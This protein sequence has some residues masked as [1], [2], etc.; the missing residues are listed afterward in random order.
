MKR[1]FAIAGLMT[2]AAISLTNCQPKEIGADLIPAGKTVYISAS[3]DAGVKTTNDGVKTLWAENDAIN[4]FCTSGSGYTDLGE[5]TIADGVGTTQAT[6]AVT[7]TALPAEDQEVTWYAMYPYNSYLTTPGT[8]TDARTYIGHSVSIEQEG[9]DNMDKL[10]D[11]RCPMYGVA[12]GKI[13][14]VNIPMKHLT[15]VVEFNITNNSGSGLTVK[16]V[17]MTASEDIVGQ[18]YIA[19]DGDAPVYTPRGDTYVKKSALVNLTN[20]TLASGASGKVYLPIKPY[21]Q[22]DSE[23]LLVEVVCT[24]DGS[25]KTATFELNPTG[26]KAVFSAGKIKPVALE[27]QKFTEKEYPVIDALNSTGAAK[28]VGAV[29]TMVSSKTFFI[30]DDTGSM[31]VYMNATPTVEKGDIVTVEGNV[32]TSRNAKRFSN[33]ASNPTT[34]TVTGEANPIPADSWS[35]SQV[36][37]A[38]EQENN[39]A[40]VTFTATYDGSYMASVDGAGDVKIYIAERAAGVNLPKSG[41]VCTMTGFVCGWSLYQETTKE[42]IFFAESIEVQGGSSAYLSVSPTSVD[43]DQPGGSAEVEVSSDDNN[44]TIDASSVPDWLTAIKSGTKV[45]FSADANTEQKRSATVTIN[46]SNGSLSKTV[47]VSQEGAVVDDILSLSAASI[48]FGSTGNDPIVLTVTCNSNNWSIDNSTVP[49]WLTVTP[50]NQSE[51]MTIT[52]VAQDNTGEARNAEVVVNHPNGTLSRTLKVGQNAA[53]SGGSSTYVK[54]TSASALTD[55]QYLIVYEEASVAMNG[56]L[57]T[58]DAASNNKSVTISGNSITW[59]GDDIYFTYKSSE[60]SLL[61]AGGVYLAHNEKKNNILNGVSTY[62][63]ASCELDISFDSDG[64]VIILSPAGYNL[65]YNASSGQNRFRFYSTTST[66]KLVQLY[67][68]Q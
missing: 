65:R 45:T 67:K 4:L 24:V 47:K 42:V 37:A 3:T 1:F 41:E 18:Y 31:Q 48:S 46:H 35:G 58:L 62:D 59:S 5:V 40:Y 13:G 29:V 28:V 66:Q 19:I 16:S 8:Q 10:S 23:A 51:P 25:D 57:T 22:S 6:L 20:G 17:T 12:T 14:N 39:T 55:G 27:L 44:W 32:T 54:V 26:P 11:N 68:K 63:A 64:N 36:A 21:I 43:I 9:F 52:V 2:A 60:K 33:T 53:S 61:G 50:D 15:S 49:S 7:S 30:T 56:G 38:Y 34:V